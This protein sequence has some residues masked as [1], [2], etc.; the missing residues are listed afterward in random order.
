MMKVRVI[1]GGTDCGTGIVV[2]CKGELF[3][4]SFEG[5]YTIWINT[6]RIEV[7]EEK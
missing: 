6:N 1:D 5:G 2:D 7:L 4:I 3:A